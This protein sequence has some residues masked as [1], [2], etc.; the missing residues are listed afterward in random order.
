MSA[1]R[2]RICAR[3]A[4]SSIAGRATPRM[5]K[6]PGRWPDSMRLY[7]AGRSFRRVRSPDAPKMTRTQPSAALD[8][9]A[10]LRPQRRQQFFRE[11][12][13]AARPEPRVQRGGE[14]VGRHL[15]LDGCRHGPAP[16]ARVGDASLEALEV[17]IFT[18][19]ARR[20]IQQPRADDAAAPPD[21]GNLGEVELV[22]VLLGQRLARRVSQDVEA[23]GVRL[24]QPVLDAVVNHLREVPGA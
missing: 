19:R 3:Y 17:R 11:G 22:A 20:Q 10:E 13:V 9:A 4:A 15:F 12:V 16:L 18:E 6:P 21:F 8:M 14:R 2:S 5:A 7:T 23:F 24:H 1:T